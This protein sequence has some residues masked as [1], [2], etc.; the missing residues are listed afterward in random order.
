MKEKEKITVGTDWATFKGEFAYSG[1]VDS[2]WLRMGTEE[3]LYGSEDYTMT[4]IGKTYSVEITGLQ[5]G[6]FYYY[7][8]LADYGAQTKWQ[9]ELYGF[10]TAEE[11]ISLPKVNTIEIAGVTV[12]SA[13]CLCSVAEDGGAEVT[14]RGACWSD[15]P[16]PSISNST[17]ANGT[18]IGDY[19]VNLT[20]LELGT[21]YYVRAYAKN[22]KGV[23]YGEELSFTTLENLVPPFGAL[24]GLFSVE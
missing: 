22:R 15:R 23:N 5:P 9:S 3:H 13:T 6:T 19:E 14:E 7:A 11:E 17:Y 20:G 18:G 2:I 10:T 4:V 21:T 8:Y 16:N 1:V 12:S 24:N